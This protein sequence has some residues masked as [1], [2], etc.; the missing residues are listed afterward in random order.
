MEKRPTF[1]TL[2]EAFTFYNRK[3]WN[4]KLPKSCVI[5][6]KRSLISDGEKLDG[7]HIELWKRTKDKP[8][9]EFLR[10]EI[11]I[12]Y[13]LTNYPFSALITLLHE[14]THLH[15]KLQGYMG[16]GKRFKAERKRLFLLGAYDD[17]L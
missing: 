6:L 14:M 12:L 3:Y 15:L 4:N 16:H 10:H 11:W 7:C 17:L 5:R 8:N 1:Y 13:A 2:E 9:G